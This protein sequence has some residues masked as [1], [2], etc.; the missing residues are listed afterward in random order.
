MVMPLSF[1]AHAQQDPEILLYEKNTLP[2]AEEQTLDDAGNVLVVRRITNPSITPFIPAG[3]N[4]TAVIICPGGGYYNEHIRREGFRVAEAFREQGIAAFVLKYSLPDEE[5]VGD[6]SFAPL[7]DAQRAIE[8][9]R[10]KSSVW[11]IDTT[12][13]GIMGFS[14]GG[15][16]ASSAGVHCDTILVENKQARVRPDFMILVYP[17]ITFD[18][19]FTHLG[20]RENLIGKTPS[21]EQIRYFSNELQVNK[22]TPPTILF[23]ASDDTLVP[24]ANSLRF[25]E[26]LQKNGVSAEMHLYFAG[27]HGFSSTPTLDEWFGRCLNWIKAKNSSIIPDNLTLEYLTRPQGLDEKKPRFSWTL[28]AV[29]ENQFAQKQSAYRI[30]VA[31]SKE[32][33]DKNVGDLWDSGWIESDDM[34]L[35][36]YDGAAL[37]SDKTCYWKVAVKDEKGKVSPWSAVAEWSTGLFSQNEWTAKWIGSK[38]LFDYQSNDCNVYDP[39]LRKNVVLKEKPHR[40]VLFVASVGYHEVYV[41]GEKIGDEV[42]A[43]SVTDHTKRARYIAYDIAPAL[44]KGKNTIALWLGAS[45]SIF[46]PYITPD[47]PRTPIVSAQAD[48]YNIDGQLINRIKT[49]DSWKIHP[50]PNRLTGKWEFGNYGGEIW[51]DTRT[52]PEWNL[53]GF[54]DSK[55][56]QAT[57]YAPQLVLSAQQVEGNRLF[58]EIKPVS[59]ENRGNGVYRIDMGVNFAGWT[60]ITVHA[61]PGDTVRFFFSEREQDEMTFG[62]RSAIVVGQSGKATFRNRFNYSSGRWITV[63]GATSKPQLSDVLG[64]LVRTSFQKSTTFTCSDPLQ[65]WIYNRICW[66]FQNLSIGG[67]IVDCPQRERFGYG[68]DAH[69]TSETGLFNYRL[70]A[71]YTKWLED[72]RDV[73]GTE[74]M[75]GNMND[76]AWA[77]KQINSGRFFGNGV[78][79]HTAPTYH[80]GGG[81]AWGGIVVTLPWLIYQHEG[82]TRVLEKNYGMLKGWLEFLDSHT[83]NH[84]LQ[85]F[86]GSWDF[87]GDWLWPNATAEGMNNNKPE[88]L[89]F[90]NCYRVY[91]LRTAAKIARVLGRYSDA[92]KWE[93]QAEASSRAIHEKFYNPDDHSYADASMANLAAALYGNVMHAELR[94]TIMDRLEREI[95]VHKKGHIHVG[96]TGGAMLFKVLRDEGRDDLIYSMTSQTDYPGWGFMRENGATTIWEMWE[97]DLPGHSL[98]HSSYLYPGAWYVD[99][100]A[101]IRRDDHVPGFRKFIIRVPRLEEKQLSWAKAIYN[102]PAGKI[103]SHWQKDENR[104][105]LSISVPPN[106]T[107]NVFFPKDG[108]KTI[109]GLN[110]YIRKIGEDN[111]CLIFEVPAGKYVFSN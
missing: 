42:L 8:I 34:Q 61:A 31:C 4:K 87:L 43:P 9:V 45:W 56:T 86:G 95:L 103:E 68:G 55:W 15:H 64:R 108:G 21:A 11:G 23:H 24:V 7:K 30:L 19:R 96:I 47:K 25:Y 89:C 54:D 35:I 40:A 94:Q 91:N 66:T 72:W 41:N 38:Q 50:S 59:V 14:A 33:L 101:G 107:A 49:D 37:L 106:C 10:E 22:N 74:S 82:D 28:R 110:D 63:K 6:K 100:V 84:L 88:T 12:K 104:L 81:P 78:L 109:K 111:D 39:W 46:A 93:H 1:A 44:K 90:N 76:P 32:T 29:D 105:R 48:L 5:I 102:S 75:V 99:G 51:D 73:Q 79:P 52:I 71:F 16:L 26:A 27:E 57:Q 80:G 17:V 62:I 65:N 53:A 2:V 58:D 97:K 3:E 70:G 13:V 18:E 20:S 83:E 77:H 69:A 85:R 60:Q 36:A 67:Y 98:L 92:E